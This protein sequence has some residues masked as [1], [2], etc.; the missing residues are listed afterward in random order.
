MPQRILQVF[1]ALLSATQLLAAEREPVSFNLQVRPILSDRCLT[2]H[3]PD[4]NKRKAKLRLDTKEGALAQKDG[5]Y[6]VKP[7]DP[8]ASELYKRL[9]ST[10]PEE[11]M[12]PAE[13]HLTVSP[14]EVEIIR[15]WIAEGAAWEKHWAYVPPR[16]RAIPQVVG[17]N[18]VKNDI[19]RFILARLGKEGLKPAGEASREK[20]IR[21]LSF[22]LTGLPPALNEVD[23][24]V[25]DRS[26]N[27]YEK[28][29]DRLLASKSFGE[30]MA[31][32]WLDLSRY[33]DTH[34][35]QADK[36]RAMWPWRDWVIKSFNE[37]LPY[38]QFVTWQLAGDLL[39]N[40]TKEQILATA[41]N[42]HHMQ[43]EEGGS[44]EEE[45]RVTYVVDRVNTMGT[46]FMAQT[47]EC[48][49]CHD[50]KYDPISQKD[51]YS[52]FSFF[53]NI[54]E[55]GQD[56]H[57]TDAMPV[58]TLLM[59]DEATDKRLAVL[60][61]QIVSK[62]AEAAAIRT[63]ARGAFEAWLN[64]R[65][66]EAV[67]PGLIADISFEEI[68]ENKFA[69][70]ANGG[71][72]ANAVEGPVIVEEGARGKA[73]SLNGENG[74]TLNDLGT[75]SRTDPFS[76]AVWIRTPVIPN[77]AVIFHRSMAALDAASR[78]TELGRAVLWRM[79]LP[80][81]ACRPWRVCAPAARAPRSP[82]AR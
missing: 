37:N 79:A 11:R 50:H 14:E 36:Y 49:R 82:A 60:K 43:T 28:L 48:S 25:A 74:V 61:E 80:Q 58:P 17:T 81:P 12:P 5:H 47:F 1:A 53:N 57:F 24:F 30:R 42:R 52:L 41:F 38:D 71:K 40:A 22:D 8:E 26:E 20:L 68:K 2:C 64:E 78:Q 31:V 16:K 69:N 18:W 33:S 75:F 59:S 63:N 70:A 54:D 23:A 3:G 65:P 32:D 56:S 66:T 19:D 73:L 39:P 34:G 44:V 15:R 62:E 10:D 21:R 72:P 46:A 6:I 67:V 45:F 4:E 29:V 35:Y 76:I 9:S 7:G 13:S 77:R 55:S 51:F 27:A